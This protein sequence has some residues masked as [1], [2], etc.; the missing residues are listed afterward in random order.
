MACFLLLHFLLSSCSSPTI[1]SSPRC[2][3]ASLATS[4][5]EGGSIKE[6]S[7]LSSSL[8]QSVCPLHASPSPPLSSR[9][10]LLPQSLFNSPLT[11][12][13]PLHCLFI[14]SCC[15]CS[16]AH[17]VLWRSWPSMVCTCMSSLSNSFILLSP[18]HLLLI[19]FINTDRLSPSD[20][21]FL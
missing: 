6:T 11:S 1:L 7:T 18:F 13:P 20:I 9:H 5:K 8:Q 3:S 4:W 10:A 14:I 19:N 2:S 21:Y 17:T 16:D 15:C 12:T